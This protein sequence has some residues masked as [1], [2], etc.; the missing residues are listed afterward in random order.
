MSIVQ[1]DSESLQLLVAQ[2]CSTPKGRGGRGGARNTTHMS[3]LATTSNVGGPSS[4]TEAGKCG[5]G[6]CV[7]DESDSDSS[8][9]DSNDSDDE[10]SNSNGSGSHSNSMPCVAQRGKQVNTPKSKQV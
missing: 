9:F 6:S 1:I 7:S 5:E 4:S 3:S 2:S 8:Y 10:T